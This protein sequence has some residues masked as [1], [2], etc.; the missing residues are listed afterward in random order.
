[1]KNFTFQKIAIW[2]VTVLFHILYRI[3][4]KGKENI[5]E[6]NYIVCANHSQKSDSVFVVTAIGAKHRMRAMGKKELWDIKPLGWILSGIGAFPVDRKSADVKAI[7]TSMKALNDGQKL[8]IFPE[9]TRKQEFDGAAKAGAAMLAQ[10]T[11]SPVLPV[12]IPQNK[13]MFSK[14]TII[15]GE[16]FT[17]EGDRKEGYQ[18]GA[19][20]IVRKIYSLAE[21]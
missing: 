13:K 19:D 11:N 5:K 12:Y 14:V 6:G 8:I 21:K 16:P 9:G 17:V 20:E 7:K 1:M 3:E 18:K 4:V 10:R 15:F 2:V